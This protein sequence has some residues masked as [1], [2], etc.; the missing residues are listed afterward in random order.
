MDNEKDL[1]R[2]ERQPFERTDSQGKS[3]KFSDYEAQYS[4]KCDWKDLLSWWDH[5]M[6]AKSAEVVHTLIYEDMQQDEEEYDRE[7]QRYL[8]QWTPRKANEAE[9]DDGIIDVAQVTS[10]SA[11]E[12]QQSRSRP[13]EMPP[14]ECQ[15]GY[16]ILT[17]MEKK[18]LPSCRQNLSKLIAEKKF[19]VN[20]RTGRLASSS[21]HETPNPTVA[22]ERNPTGK[23]SSSLRFAPKD[24]L[25]I[26]EEQ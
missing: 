2:L 18:V 9:S 14:A 6:Q 12:S 16:L 23:G 19:E 22:I 4:W 1:D 21:S 11:N 8:L 20:L 7:V 3:W 5:C 24:L 13:S 15:W 10:N 26:A 25:G 17:L